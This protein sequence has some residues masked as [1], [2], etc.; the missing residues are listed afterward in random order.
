MFLSFSLTSIMSTR[1]RN[2]QLIVS[3]Y[4][5][6]VVL[7]ISKACHRKKYYICSQGVNFLHNSCCQTCTYLL[8]LTQSAERFSSCHVQNFRERPATFKNWLIKRE[9]VYIIRF[10]NSRRS[11][12]FL[13]LMIHDCEFLER[14]QNLWYRSNHSYCISDKDTAKL[15]VHFLNQN[16]PK[17]KY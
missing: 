8:F 12:E 13:Q 2:K 9:G 7:N 15:Y 11:R 14:L 4:L 3:I 17:S 6:S 16:N 1:E 10:K 5:F